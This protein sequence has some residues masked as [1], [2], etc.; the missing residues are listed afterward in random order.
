MFILFYAMY[1]EQVAV[2]LFYATKHL[3]VAECLSD[4]YNK[5]PRAWLGHRVPRRTH[6]RMYQQHTYFYRL[7]HPPVCII[8]YFYR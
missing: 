6:V 2:I 4:E 1:D 7:V 5:S 3:D 8:Q